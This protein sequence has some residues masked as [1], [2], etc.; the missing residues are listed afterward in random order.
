[1]DFL[2]VMWQIVFSNMKKRSNTT[3]SEHVWRYFHTKSKIVLQE[4]FGYHCIGKEAEK[5]CVSL[6]PFRCVHLWCPDKS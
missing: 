3:I 6:L 2:T 4:G 1:M 5:D